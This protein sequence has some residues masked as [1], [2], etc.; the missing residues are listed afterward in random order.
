LRHS[1]AFEAAGFWASGANIGVSVPS[2]GEI[3]AD[4]V[5]GMTKEEA[6]GFVSNSYRNKL[7]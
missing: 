4:Q 6:E 3:L 2:L 1:S 7:Y 5:G